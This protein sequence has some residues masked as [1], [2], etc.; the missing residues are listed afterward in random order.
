MALEDPN[1]RKDRRAAEL[2]PFAPPRVMDDVYTPEQIETLLAAVHRA[3]PMRL[4][5]AELFSSAE[6]IMATSSGTVDAN[7]TIDNFLD[8]MFRG[9]LAQ[10]SGCY[11]PTIEST[12]YNSKLL[13]WARDY[14]QAEIV[15]PR[16]LHYNVGAP[17]PG[18]DPGHCDA[19]AFRGIS[20]TNT[21]VWLLAV[22]AN[23]MLFRDYALQLCAVVTWFWRTSDK[24]GFTY[25]PDGAAAEPKRIPAPLWN[26]GCLAE[27]ESM[28]H[29]G[30]SIGDESQWS[31]VKGLTFNSLFEGDPQGPDRWQIRNGDEVIARFETEQLRWL[32]H[33]TALTF[34]DRAAFREY[35]DHTNDLTHERIFDI[36]AR[37]L[38]SE[39]IKV[40]LPS[41]PMADGEFRALLMRHYAIGSPKIYPAEAPVARHG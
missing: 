8:P 28:F 15:L 13:Q 26:R 21:P 27:N 35:A 7:V 12:F 30:E 2:R 39:G 40:T 37:D 11:D 14:R 5:V 36:L 18:Y 31:Q 9:D 41:D 4:L 22:M 29:R 20:H 33:W 16:Q 19:P 17:A 34:R 32:F 6:E 25:W 38:K 1:D 3:P 23:S 24:G 10:H